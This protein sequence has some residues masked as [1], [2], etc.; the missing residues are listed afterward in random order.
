[1]FAIVN[2]E[3][4]EVQA[5]LEDRPKNNAYQLPL[6]SVYVTSAEASS[7]SVPSDEWVMDEPPDTTSHLVHTPGTIV[8]ANTLQNAI[9]RQDALK[10][11]IQT[12]LEFAQSINGKAF[13]ALTTNELKNMLQL[14]FAMFGMVDVNGN[15]DLSDFTA[16]SII[17]SA[18]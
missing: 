3:T 15:V 6:L 11:R 12:I 17:K 16:D 7:L 4:R 13:S 9:N 14:L 2:T 10:V 8:P 1:M 5:I 18:L